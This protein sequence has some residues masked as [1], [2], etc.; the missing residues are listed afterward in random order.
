VSRGLYK[1]DGDTLTIALGDL[2]AERPK[3]LASRPGSKVVLLT[4]R[5]AKP[6]D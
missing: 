2:N 5:R 6:Q 4:L 3:E 1:V